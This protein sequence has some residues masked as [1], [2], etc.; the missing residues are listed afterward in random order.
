MWVAWGEIKPTFAYSDSTTFPTCSSVWIAAPYA[1]YGDKQ[2]QI[3]KKK[4]EKKWSPKAY[5]GLWF[6]EHKQTSSTLVQNAV[7]DF[8]ENHL[9]QPIWDK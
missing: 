1:L 2:T 9:W 6:I 3:R 4:L 7:D 5:I 8:V